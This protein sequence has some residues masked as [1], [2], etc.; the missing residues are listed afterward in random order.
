MP[1]DRYNLRQ[2]TIESSPRSSITITRS[3]PNRIDFTERTRRFQDHP[4][5]WALSFFFPNDRDAALYRFPH[6]WIEDRVEELGQPIPNH[7]S[8]RIA[9]YYIIVPYPPIQAQLSR[10]L[11]EGPFQLYQ[12]AKRPAAVAGTTVANTV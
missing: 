7:P 9:S 6:T 3:S 4:N 8:I 1:S 2:S 12:E 5:N 10:A 11:K